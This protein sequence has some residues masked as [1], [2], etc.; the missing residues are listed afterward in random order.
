MISKGHAYEKLA[1]KYLHQQGCI[2]KDRNYHIR[3]G[4]IDLI[5][6]DNTTL[7]F[8]EVRY[9]KNTTFGTPEETITK[10][11]QN[12]IKLTAQHYMT[13]FNLWNCNARFDV[14]TIKPTANGDIKI[15]WLKSAFS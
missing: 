11:K 1:E 10:S 15:N 8:V 9:R 5:A 13:K 12:K 14:V 4:E 7:V 2:I 6:L 3:K